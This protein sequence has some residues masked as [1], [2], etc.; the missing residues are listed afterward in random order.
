MSAVLVFLGALLLLSPVKGAIAGEP[1]V[2]SFTF[3][4]TAHEMQC[5]Y[6]DVFEGQEVDVEFQVIAGGALDVDFYYY[7]PR[8]V[9]IIERLKATDGHYTA[10]AG[11]S[12]EHRFC[13][14]NAMSTIQD[15]WVFIDLGIDRQKAYDSWSSSKAPEKPKAHDEAVEVL[16]TSVDKLR[17]TLREVEHTQAYLRVREARHRFTAE[18]T[19]ERV[20]WWSL[21]QSSLI[22]FTALTQVFFV[23]RFF[24]G[25]DK[26]IRAF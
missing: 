7:D 24:G 25:G 1:S 13:F 8:G 21:V 20:F 18:S 16:Q 10:T 14:S 23:R 19:N 9:Q 2:T 12:G 15:K 6:E 5:F 22:V 17:H 26:K 3:Q 11:V 4:L